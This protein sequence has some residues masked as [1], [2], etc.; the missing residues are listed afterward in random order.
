MHHLARYLTYA[1]SGVLLLTLFG[2]DLDDPEAPDEETDHTPPA[3]L[4]AHMLDDDGTPVFQD[5]VARFEDFSHHMHGTSMVGGIS[6]DSEMG[7]TNYRPDLAEEA[8]AQRG[9]DWLDA[10]TILQR[11]F[12]DDGALRSAVALDG[13]P[14]SSDETPDL[15][16]YSPATYAY[17]IHHRADRW[18]DH[19]LEDAMTYDPVAYHTPLGGYL[20]DTHYTDG[21]LTHDAEGED[22]DLRSM[23]HAGAA[24]H[25]AV[26]AWVRWD[27]P[28]G[29]DDM[30][31][32]SEA[33]LAGWMGGYDPDT[34]VDM[35]RAQAETWDD[36]WDDDLGAYHDG[37]GDADAMTLDLETVGALLHAHKAWYEMLHVFGD[38]DDREQARQLFDR[39]ATLLETTLDLAEPWGL[40]DR[41]R[42]ED[43][44]AH[45]ASDTMSVQALWTFVNH[46]TGGFSYLRERD[47]TSQYL[48]DHRPDLLDA[49]NDFTD[50]QLQGALDYQLADDRLVT[51]LDFESSDVIDDTARS[52]PIGM[53]LTA[54]GNAYSNGSAFAAASDW[55]DV[56]D[57]VA[58]RTERLYDLMVAHA[59]LLE[60]TFRVDPADL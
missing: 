4:V 52:A 47:G 16:L 21:R 6:R 18:A 34:M 20:M 14:V 39:S 8:Q 2:C 3:F 29:A 51:A 13:T 48:T 1:L 57:D 25:G 38:D 19:G 30:G 46:L 17:H 7:H 32:L 22:A 11:Y 37:T 24:L 31:Q 9:E 56:D 50:A 26:Y 10:V 55:D 12:S 36:W 28:G 33:H 60:D 15:R 53:F 45:A 5:D 54:A 59:E 43:G 23:S 44:T 27:K 35:A 40:P 58:Q 42:F 41:I 49:A